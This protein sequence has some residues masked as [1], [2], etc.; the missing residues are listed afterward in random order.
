MDDQFGP[1]TRI[2]SAERCGYV[3]NTP[4]RHLGRRL[5]AATDLWPHCQQR[6]MEIQNEAFMLEM[7]S[8]DVKE[9]SQEWAN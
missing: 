9:T 3:A 2:V 1:L 6:H 5:Y 7:D 4:L 8:I